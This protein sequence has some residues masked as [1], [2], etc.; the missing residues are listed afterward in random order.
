MS[1]RLQALVVVVEIAVHDRV[2][3]LRRH[4]LS[5]AIHEDMPG[6]PEQIRDIDPEA[7]DEFDDLC[8][9]VLDARLFYLMLRTGWAR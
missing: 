1:T 3:R 8:M 5:T 6:H 9:D 4:L 7:Q 2:A